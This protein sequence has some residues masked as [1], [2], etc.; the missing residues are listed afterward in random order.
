MSAINEWF[1]YYNAVF[2]FI[3]D[4]YGD[5]EL[6]EYLC[7]LAREAYSDITPMYREG[8]LSAI[9]ERYVKNF[10]KDGDESSASY[11]IEGDTLTIDVHC[12]AFT[13]C[14]KV[15]DPSRMPGEFFCTCCDRLNREILKNAGYELDLCR[16]TCGECKW[17][18][19]KTD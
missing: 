12:P 6:E 13:H 17:K 3:K 4:T 10:R 15:E 16:K 5:G 7:H 11:L 19:K 14:V 9:A 2:T 18:I 1:G 8:G